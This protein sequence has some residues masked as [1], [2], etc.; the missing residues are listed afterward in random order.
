ME[1]VKRQ[2]LKRSKIVLQY[3]L[4]NNFLKEF[5]S[6][7]DAAKQLTLSQCLIVNCCNGGYWRD[8]HTKFIKCNRVKNYIFK[9]KN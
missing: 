4:N 6:T 2:V 1:E 5:K 9:Y 3:D 7:Q 8:K